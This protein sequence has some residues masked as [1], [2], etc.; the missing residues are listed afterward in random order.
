MLV[1]TKYT[2]VPGPHTMLLALLQTL[3]QKGWE[4]LKDSHPQM[5]SMQ[6]HAEK[7]TKN[8]HAS[9]V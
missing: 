9:Y 2:A 8:K 3:Q 5:L 1:L 7:N 6:E 4:T